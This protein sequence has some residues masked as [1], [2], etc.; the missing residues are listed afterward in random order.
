MFAD[1]VLRA[2]YTFTVLLVTVDTKFWQRAINMGSNITVHN[3]I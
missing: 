2:V 3:D 1:N